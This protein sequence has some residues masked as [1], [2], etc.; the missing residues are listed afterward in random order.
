MSPLE[1]K[2]WV[3]LIGSA[4]EHSLSPAIHNRAFATRDVPWRYITLPVPAGAPDAL[5][6]TLT[7]LKPR[8]FAGANITVPH[9]ESALEM[10]DRCTATVQAI[11]AANS[12][13]VEADGTLTAHNTDIEGFARSLIAQGGNIRG[14]DALI[15]G[16]GGAARAVTWA[17]TQGGA[18]S[19]TLVN[20]DVGRAQALLDDLYPSAARS[21]LESDLR[22]RPWSESDISELLSGPHGPSLIINTTPLGSPSHLGQTP[23]PEAIAPDPR[24]VY[25]DLVYHPRPTPFLQRA[26]AAGAL[27]IDGLGMLLE[28]AALAFEIWH[29]KAPA[30]D[31]VY[32]MLRESA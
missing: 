10:V 19:V 1:T 8:G 11:G 3:G 30:T 9:K 22:A 23:W 21:T 16:A 27:T 31:A 4:P 28:Q 2:R 5:R 14:E 15:F 25:V 26:A 12:I 32:A 20:R 13:R 24:A 6:E 7:S 29:G 17:L 18:R